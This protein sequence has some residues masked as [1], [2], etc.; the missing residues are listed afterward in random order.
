MASI[1]Y[2]PNVL[3]AQ[4]QRVPPTL[5]SDPLAKGIRQITSALFP[6]VDRPAIES[7]DNSR[8]LFK[9]PKFKMG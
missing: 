4:E 2:D 3:A 1:G 5:R 9:L 6:S 8:A 7:A